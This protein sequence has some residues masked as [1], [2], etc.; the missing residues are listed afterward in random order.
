MLCALVRADRGDEV[1]LVERDDPAGERRSVFQYRHPHFFRP[2]VPSIL[3]SLAP[4]ALS[5]ILDAGGVLDS[6]PGAPPEIQG[7]AVRRS[8]LEPAF[9]SVV[10]ADPR[11]TVVHGE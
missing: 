6:P 11:I 5:A 7:L 9:R 1:T 4:Q 3:G 2:Q 8:V 10:D